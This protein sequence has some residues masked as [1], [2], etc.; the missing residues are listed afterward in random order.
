[1]ATTKRHRWLRAGLLVTLGLTMVLATTA[2]GVGARPDATSALPRSQTLY[3]SGK[4]WGPYTDFN[5]FRSG[6][7]ATGV[8]GLVYETLFRYDPLKDRYIPWLATNGRWQGTTYVAT[9]RRGVKWSD[10]KPFT[11][12]D[13]KYSFE[14]GKLTGLRLRHDVALRAGRGHHVG[15]LHGA[16][17]LPRDAQLPAVGLLPLQRPDRPAAHLEGVQRHPGHDRQQRQHEPADRDRAVRLRRR[18]GLVADPDLEAAERLVGDEGA[19]QADVDDAHRRHPQHVEHRVAAELR[20]RAD[21]PQQQLLPRGRQAH[22]REHPDVLH[23]GAVHARGQHGLARPE[24]DEGAAQRPRLP[25]GARDLDQHQ[26]DREGRLR[27]HRLEGER[28]RPAADLE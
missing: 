1:M 5:P 18:Q 15:R 21:R 23:A 3:V 11:S 8:V 20:V 16:L 10:G 12:R 25:Q 6:D 17:P 9:L 28:D 7:Y 22:P 4:Q 24:H 27:Q 13:V 14:T 2:S 19:R 26:P